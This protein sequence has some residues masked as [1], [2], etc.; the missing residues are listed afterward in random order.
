MEKGGADIT[1]SLA[2]TLLLRNLAKAL[3]AT[4]KSRV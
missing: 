4:V 2:C 1:I 3:G